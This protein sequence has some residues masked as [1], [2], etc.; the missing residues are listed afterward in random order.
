[1]T[2]LLDVLRSR[3]YILFVF[4]RMDMA[5]IRLKVPFNYTSIHLH[6]VCVVYRYG[7]LWILE[8]SIFAE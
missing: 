1:M 6:D 2:P 8:G 5:K 7:T 3:Q 4:C